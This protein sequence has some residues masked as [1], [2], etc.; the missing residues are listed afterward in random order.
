M[1][2]YTAAD[3]RMGQNEI[4]QV[5]AFVCGV[6]V[7][8]LMIMGLASTD[9]LMA[10]G[11][12]QGLFAHCIED[13]APTPLPFH[14][15][16]PAGCYQARDVGYIKAAAALCVVCLLAD[17]AATILTGLGLRSQDHRDKHKYYL[18]A[19]FCMGL[20]L[21][22]LLIALVV[23][24]VCFAAELNHGNRTMWEFGWAYGV[25]W[26]AAIFLFGGAVLLLC[27]KESEEIYYKERKIVRDDIGGGGGS[28]I[29]V[30]HHGVRSG[31][32]LA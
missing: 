6:I 31:T 14:M 9:W 21:A 27:D 30:G 17:I 18:F 28:M 13:G 4:A 20:A 29:G 15:T 2:M 12:R 22:A 8:L 11:W 26:G 10:L 25:G 7:I 24:P 23:Y 16:T 19:V 32:Q 3:N 1:I 5:I